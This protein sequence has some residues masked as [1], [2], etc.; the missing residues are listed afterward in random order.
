MSGGLKSKG[1][2]I[3][4]TGLGQIYELVVQLRGEAAARQVPGANSGIAKAPAS[5]VIVVRV[6]LA[7]MC[8]APVFFSERLVDPATAS[9]YAQVVD[10]ILNAPDIIAGRQPP[11]ALGVAAPDEHTVAI[12]LSAP[13][14]YLPG[15]MAHPSCAPLHRASLASLGEKFARAGSQVSNGAFVLEEW[16]EG[17]SITFARNDASKKVLEKAGYKLEGIMRRSA[18]KDGEILD[19]YLYAVTDLDAARGP[20]TK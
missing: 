4:A 11:A 7:L 13:A 3:G 17:D 16:R 8:M 12:T 1:H 15:L 18:I 5:P 14:P 19:Q 9:Q 20:D 2:P 6:S 10:V